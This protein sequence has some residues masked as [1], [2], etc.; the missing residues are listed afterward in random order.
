LIFNFFLSKKSSNWGSRQIDIKSHRR[1]K[2]GK[3]SYRQKLS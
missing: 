2:K 3:I 1:I